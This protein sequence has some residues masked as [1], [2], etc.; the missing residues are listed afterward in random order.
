MATT[1]KNNVTSAQA[2]KARVSAQ[3]HR[4]VMYKMRTDSDV[5]WVFRAIVSGVVDD[6]SDIDMLLFSKH[7]S[8]FE[9][10]ILRREYEEARARNRRIFRDPLD[11]DHRQH[12]R[13]LIA[14]NRAERG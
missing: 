2:K 14:R 9:S 5:Q 1:N 10:D 3:T 8:S 12:I 6:D 13:E 7:R 4:S 11:F